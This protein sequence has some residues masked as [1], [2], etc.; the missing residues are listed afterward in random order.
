MDCCQAYVDEVG[1]C[2]TLEPTWFVYTGG[3][4]PGVKVGLINYP[5][6]PSSR[7]EIL[8][9]AMEVA[10]ILMRKLWQTSCSIVT[11]N[12]TYRLV[13]HELV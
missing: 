8:G 3:S 5:R 13:N 2:V 12:K 4:E 10:R 1:L 11:S 6:F 9:H 7:G